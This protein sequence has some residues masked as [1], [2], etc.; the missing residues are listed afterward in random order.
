MQIQDSLV[1]CQLFR[2][3]DTSN[4]ITFYK[5]FEVCYGKTPKAIRDAFQQEENRQTA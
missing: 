3:K 5:R 1:L 2:T 4:L